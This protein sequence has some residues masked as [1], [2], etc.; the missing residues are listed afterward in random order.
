MS[1]HVSALLLLVEN[2]KKKRS[3]VSGP[4]EGGCARRQPWGVGIQ[5]QSDPSNIL[6]LSYIP[7][8]GRAIAT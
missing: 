4:G 5:I 1:A 2:Q 7:Y 6:H 8:P 3:R